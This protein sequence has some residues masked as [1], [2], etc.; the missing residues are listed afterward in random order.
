MRTKPKR[1]RIVLVMA[2]SIIV[3]VIAYR[4]YQDEKAREAKRIDMIGA[5]QRR[6]L[7]AENQ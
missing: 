2:L 7:P 4:V 1:W 3:V 6:S 5:I